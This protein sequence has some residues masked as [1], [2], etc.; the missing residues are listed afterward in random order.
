MNILFYIPNISRENG[1]IF[2][3]SIRLLDS[4][5]SAKDNIFIYNQSDPEYFQDRYSKSDQ[6][7]LVQFPSSNLGSRARKKAQRISTSLKKEFAFLPAFPSETIPRKI[8]SKY[9]IDLVH[10]PYQI[11]PN[12][13]VPLIF[14]LHDVQE[15]HFPEYFSPWEREAR[16]RNNRIGCEESAGI[17][18]SYA[19]VKQD[20]IRYFNVPEKKIHVLF[21]GSSNP[22]LQPR[23]SPSPDQHYLLYPA[24]TWPHKNHINLIKAFARAKADN[25][26]MKNYRLICTG[27]LTPFFEEIKQLPELTELGHAV[28]F[29]GLVSDEE[30]KVLYQNCSGVI[31]PTKYEAGS[32][33]LMEA[34][35][36]EIPVICSNVTS[37]PEAIAESDFTFNPE[38]VPLISELIQKLCLDKEF[39]SRN[40]KNSA[41]RRDSIVNQ[42]IGQELEAIYKLTLA[43]SKTPGQYNSETS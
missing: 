16:A 17:I 42:E 34:M 13:N 8:L 21:I 37:L 18:V 4:L 26:E 12:N 20:V 31:I 28:E 33:P 15:L 41:D 22:E 27:H 24:A 2:Q 40:K 38:N 14:T 9:K 32:F 19:H 6:I 5:T 3:Y 11:F 1:G 30:L 29:K 39:I 43:A 35:M 10:S 36:Q 25:A 23:I 7:H